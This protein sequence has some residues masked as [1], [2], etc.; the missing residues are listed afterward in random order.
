MPQQ[1]ITR[2]MLIA[3]KLKE[4][5]IEAL[6]DIGCDFGSLLMQANSFGIRS[7]G[8]DIDN[9]SLSLC[10]SR[11]LVVRKN[12]ITEIVE[13]KFVAS[14]DFKKKFLVTNQN[15]FAISCLNILH[16]KQIKKNLRIKF[17][18][19]CLNEAKVF[20]GTFTN[21]QLK[22][23][24]KYRKNQGFDPNVFYIS[25][26]SKS[27]SHLSLSIMQYGRS[28]YLQGKYSF[29]ENIFWNIFG[30]KFIFPNK[31]E[32]YSRLVAIIYEPKIRV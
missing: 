25:H 9:K 7:A 28:F 4:L 22:Q 20:V 17:I 14:L 23:I 24:L 1:L 21:S 5:K 30:D 6:L 16:S 29:I 3:Q 10:K 12:S 15:N 31:I 18:N 32:S 8:Y 27:P 26:V 2:D 19:I 13:K 11:K